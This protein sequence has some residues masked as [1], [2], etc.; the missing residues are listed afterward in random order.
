[1]SINSMEPPVRTGESLP[2]ALVFQSAGNT[3]DPHESDGESAE[4]Q[5]SIPAV[6]ESEGLDAAAFE[7][8]SD[9][10]NCPEPSCAEPESD[11]LTLLESLDRRQNLVLDELDCLNQRVVDLMKELQLERDAA[12]RETADTSSERTTN[13]RAS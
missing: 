1:M 11:E 6:A 12:L 13:T 3:A 10:P 4:L 7:S 8:E 2:K 9:E 5:E